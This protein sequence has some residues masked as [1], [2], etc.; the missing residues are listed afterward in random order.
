MYSAVLYNKVRIRIKQN[1]LFAPLLLHP[2]TPPQPPTLHSWLTGGA[3]N[4]K[5][6]HGNTYLSICSDVIR[7]ASETR[8]QNLH[9]LTNLTLNKI[10][11]TTL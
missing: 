2:R 5:S 11:I 1:I 4:Q 9:V 7:C 10:S 8:I 6:L 3:F